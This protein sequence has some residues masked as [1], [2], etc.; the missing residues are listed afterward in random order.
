[1]VGFSLG[2]EIVFEILKI[3]KFDNIKKVVLICS[4]NPEKSISF[5]H[6]EIVNIYSPKDLITKYAIK[7]LEPFHGG[8]RLI[9]KNVKNVIVSDMRHRDFVF[10][11]IIKKG[12]YKGK[13]ITQLV[14]LMLGD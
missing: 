4:I 1:M 13:T 11:K 2:G 8:K 3:R 10:D 14:N 6:P 7:V 5:K 9:G 12:R